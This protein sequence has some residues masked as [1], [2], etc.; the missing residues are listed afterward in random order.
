MLR[1]TAVGSA[2]LVVGFLCGQ[3]AYEGGI[4]AFVLFAVIL[5]GIVCLASRRF[6]VLL[7]TLPS[8]GL[9][10]RAATINLSDTRL[11][12]SF[13]DIIWWTIVFSCIGAAASLVVS[14]PWLC[15]RR[16][17]K[18]RI[19]RSSSEALQIPEAILYEAWQCHKRLVKLGWTLTR[20]T[21]WVIEHASNYDDQPPIKKLIEEYLAEQKA[22]GVANATLIDLRTRLRKFCGRFGDRKMH[23]IT[24]TEIRKWNSDMAEIEESGKQSRRNHLNKISQFFRWAIRNK[25]CGENPLDAVKR[26]KLDQEEVAFYTVEQCRRILELAP[27]HRIYHYVVLG[28]LGTIRPAELRRMK[29]QDIHLEGRRSH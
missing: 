8:V 11:G 2:A 15:Y 27:G 23:E 6:T 1:H 19:D 20:A 18:D 5:A 14:L 21:D 28:L 17:E 13:G 3:L 29:E 7:A 9:S 24:T 12:Y 25:K 22:S 16:S 10:V 4:A 26:P